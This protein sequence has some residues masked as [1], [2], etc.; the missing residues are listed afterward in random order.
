MKWYRKPGGLTLGSLYP[1]DYASVTYPI[2]RQRMTQTLYN[3]TTRYIDYHVIT[4][5][6]ILIIAP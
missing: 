4:Q 1:A 3:L 2:G 6:H 5:A